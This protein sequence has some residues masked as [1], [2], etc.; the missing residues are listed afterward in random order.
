MS[1]LNVVARSE[2]RA[3]PGRRP[4][5]LEEPRTHR[6]RRESRRPEFDRRGPYYDNENR[7]RARNYRHSR[8]RS[9]ASNSSHGSQRGRTQ[10]RSPRLDYSRRRTD[11]HRRHLSRRSSSR[12]RR[13]PHHNEFNDRRIRYRS[14]VRE[15]RH[16]RG[17][18]G[19]AVQEFDH[20][21]RQQ[22]L[23]IRGGAPPLPPLPPQP[24]EARAMM[25]YHQRPG[26]AADFLNELRERNLICIA[27]ADILQQPGPNLPPQPPMVE[28]PYPP[29]PL[30][31][32]IP[33]DW[34]RYPQFPPYVPPFP[35]GIFRG[36]VM[37][38]GRGRWFPR[39]G[40]GGLNY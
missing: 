5:R 39:G 38:R 22:P 28:R 2:D 9:R 13:S 10:S 21:Q 7:N 40:R 12:H 18:D 15:R 4:R 30:G 1:L 31:L 35:P 37:P 32:Q 24:A 36:P 23:A 6:N 27:P 8:S 20:G 26:V 19:A 17:N 25:P 3:G 14:P 33:I 29:H 11:A 34:D 16:S